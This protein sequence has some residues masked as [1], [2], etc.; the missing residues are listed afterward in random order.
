M[1]SKNG[2]MLI[3]ALLVAGVCV[4]GCTFSFGTP[5]PTPAPTTIATAPPTPAPEP[6]TAPPVATSLKT[7]VPTTTQPTSL[8]ILHES[9]MLTT[10]SYKTYDFK[11]LMG[12]K[13]LYP[14]DKFR[15]RIKSDQP[16]LGYAVSTLQ[17]G[18]LEALIPRY[19]PYIKGGIDWGLLEPVMVIDKATDTTKEFT[20]EETMPL[21][22]V[23]D[24]RWM[25]Y[26]NIYA[27]T[28]PF[29]YEITIEKIGGPT[30]QSFDFAGY[31]TN[32]SVASR[33]VPTAS[34]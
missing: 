27:N 6:T 15:I 19:Q 31:D 22:Y 14:K 29:R 7:A 13:F 18:Q 34:Y 30:K 28:G 20:L 23:V 12:F 32:S 26:E 4:T 17:A 5:T 25:G 1:I 9:G 3:V 24:G 16:L 33:T 10:K 8:V 11:T 2:I 21:T